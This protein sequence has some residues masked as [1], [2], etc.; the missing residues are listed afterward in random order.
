MENDSITSRVADT[1]WRYEGLVIMSLGQRDQYW[2]YLL[3]ALTLSIWCSSLCIEAQRQHIPP[4]SPRPPYFGLAHSTQPSHTMPQFRSRHR[5]LQSQIPISTSPLRAGVA[6]RRAVSKT[7]ACHLTWRSASGRI[8]AL[9]SAPGCT[10]CCNAATEWASRGVAMCPVRRA[11]RIATSTFVLLCAISLRLTVTVDGFVGRDTG[12]DT[13]SGD[14]TISVDVDGIW[15]GSAVGCVGDA[16]C[17]SAPVIVVRDVVT[18]TRRRLWVRAERRRAIEIGLERWNISVAGD[19][20]FVSG[21]GRNEGELYCQKLLL[22]DQSN[23]DNDCW[24]IE[25]EE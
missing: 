20:G 3:T 22:G 21:D 8:S 19:D 15:I 7:R 10:A 13:I 18:R 1:Y 16:V 4:A 23:S 25:A 12:R 17:P 14:P 5:K 11:H 24:M 6:S 9:F 2:K